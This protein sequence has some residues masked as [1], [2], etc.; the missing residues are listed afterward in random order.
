MDPFEIAPIAESRL[1]TY[2]NLYVAPGRERS[3][4]SIPSEAISALLPEQT[5]VSSHLTMGLQG[6]FSDDIVSNFPHRSVLGAPDGRWAVGEI[7]QQ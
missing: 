5:P 7:R 1:V 6:R 4:E 2:Y 3:V